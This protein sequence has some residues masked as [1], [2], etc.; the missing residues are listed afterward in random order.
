MY[1]RRATRWAAWGTV[2][3]STV[4]F[5]VLPPL[6]PFWPG[7]TTNQDWTAMNDR[8][9]TIVERKSMFVDF[10]KREA[11]RELWH[12][13]HDAA[14]AVDDPERGAARLAELGEIP[15]P[16]PVGDRFDERHAT[17]GKP[18]FWTGSAKPIGDAIVVELSRRTD[19]N[20]TTVVERRDGEFE[21][22]GWFNPDFLIYRAVGIDLTHLSDPLL[23]TLRLPT[24]I[25]LP[26][27]VMILLSSV[28][29]GNSQE[30]LDRYYAKMKTP[31]DPDPEEDRRKIARALE[32]P[33]TL[34]HKR[35]LPGTQ[36]EFQK[37]TVA[38]VAGF[39]ICFIV[40]FLLVGLAIWVARIGG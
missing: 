31:V 14:L 20:V 35:L 5:F 40:C 21:C 8:V 11:E 34:D 24:R 28:T 27:L 39:V 2:V 6:L 18:V 22:T 32:N 30:G 36:L 23:D 33:E 9:T 19:G 15:A 12:E 38:D 25:V 10:A 13:R 17:G 3:F 16:Y 7:L 26:F 29:P 1:W 4:L 37:P